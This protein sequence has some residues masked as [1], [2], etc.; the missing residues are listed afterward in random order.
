ML[1]IRLV[2]EMTYVLMGILNPI[3]ALAITRVISISHNY[4]YSLLSPPAVSVCCLSVKRITEQEAQLMLT[5][6]RD[7]FRGQSRWPNIV[8]F[9]M[10]DYAFLLVC[11]S[12]I[13]HKTHRFWDIRLVSPWSLK[14]IGTDTDRSAVYSFLLTL[15]SDQWAYLVLFPR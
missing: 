1:S 10:L 8:P 9:D 12:N 13:V 7:T 3:H 6:P 15:H 11:Y 2:S 4:L 5:K 14:V